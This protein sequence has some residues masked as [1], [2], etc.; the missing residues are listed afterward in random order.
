MR[1]TALCLVLAIFG[2]ASTAVADALPGRAGSPGGPV[3]LTILSTNDLHGALDGIVVPELAGKGERLGGFAW[4]AGLLARLKA[5]DPAHTLIV[6]AGDCFQGE[7]AVNLQEG[8]PCVRFFNAVGYDVRTIGN[9]EFDYVGCGPEAPGK[10]S[11]DP[12]CALQKVLAASSHP[13][14]VTNVRQTP[15]GRRVGWPNVVPWLVKDVGGIRVG[16]A[17]VVTP[18][19]PRV[20]NRAGSA[21]LDFTDLPGEVHQ[22]VQALRGAGATVVIVLAHVTGQCP[23]GGS[24]PGPGDA[25]CDVDGELKAMVGALKPG[26]VDL[27]VAG[28]SH[29][30]LAGERMAVP[31]METPGQGMFVGRARVSLDP[32][33]GRA[34][35]GGVRVEPPV[36]VCRVADDASKVCGAR[37]PGFAGV[38]VP[39]PAVVAVV[40]EAQATVAPICAEV[41]AEAVEDILTHRGLETPLGNLTADLLREAAPVEAGPDGRIHGADLAFLNQGSVRDSL[42]KGTVTRCD[43][44]RVWPFDDGLV[45]VRLTGAEVQRLAAFW[46][47]TVH[48]IPAV[49][50]VQ[51]TRNRDGTTVV[52][53]PDGQPLD[54]GKEYRAVTTSYLLNGGDRL[55]AFLGQLPEGRVRKL[56]GDATYRDAFARLLKARGRISAPGIGRIRTM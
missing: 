34:L 15:S 41:V 31:V 20:S 21:G 47:D 51:I 39:L 14:V 17:G 55:D 28:H 9:H 3:T 48:K 53:T 22:A 18:N 50:G 10:A 26:D 52:G 32:G 49:S 54:P 43:L 35:Q 37:Y 4:T 12:R 42:R 24:M 13:V 8:L 29:A 16:I 1:R 11:G 2:P 23:R 36:P 33:T 45:E 40:A 56:V 44:H 5:E 25:G 19:A 38:A 46:V 30:W 27:V 7:L 6:D